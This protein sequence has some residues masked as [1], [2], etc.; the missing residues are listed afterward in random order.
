[1]AIQDLLTTV[2]WARDIFK[3]LINTWKTIAEGF[4]QWQMN[5]QAPQ[6][7]INVWW[8]NDNATFDQNSFSWQIQNIMKETWLNPNSTEMQDL[9]AFLSQSTS[10][11]I[12]WWLNVNRENLKQTTG[13]NTLAT[14]ESTLISDYLNSIKKMPW[15]ASIQKNYMDKV[16]NDDINYFIWQLSKNRDSVYEM[17]LSEA[18]KRWDIV[19][20]YEVMQNAKQVQSMYDTKINEAIEIKKQRVADAKDYAKLEYEDMMNRVKISQDMLDRARVMKQDALE[21][22]RNWT[23][24]YKWL[25]ELE[26]TEKKMNKDYKL[27]LKELQ[28]STWFQN[29]DLLLKL[30][31]YENKTWETLDPTQKKYYFDEAINAKSNILSAVVNWKENS[32]D[33]VNVLKQ[34]SKGLNNYEDLWWIV[35]V[36]DS[37]KTNELLWKQGWTVAWRTNNPWNIIWSWNLETAKW[38]WAIWVYKNYWNMKSNWQPWSYLVFKT[39]EEGANAM[40][41]LMLYWKSYRNKTVADR[42]VQWQWWSSSA[43]NILKQSNPGLLSKRNWFTSEDMAAITNAVWNS[44]GWKEWTLL[45]IW[46]NTNLT[47]QIRQRA[48]ELKA[49]WATWQQTNSLLKQEFKAQTQNIPEV[50]T[51]VYPDFKPSNWQL[52]NVVQKL[53]TW[54]YV[55]TKTYKD[56]QT[57]S[58]FNSTQLAKD[59]SSVNELNWLAWDA[60]YTKLADNII[61]NYWQQLSLWDLMNTIYQFSIPNDYYVNEFKKLWYDEKT[62]AQSVMDSLIDWSTDD[63]KTDLVK[64]LYNNVYQDPGFYKK[65]LFDK[66]GGSWTEWLPYRWQ[67]ESIYDLA[68]NE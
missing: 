4:Q 7:S 32:S 42:L 30:K 9:A 63:E 10:G 38:L 53:S 47:N 1:M 50:L 39:P 21:E 46:N 54:A 51:S 2:T 22:V 55:T 36:S 14:Q 61:S 60:L 29:A 35:A 13:Y 17:M 34:Q 64:Y 3:G 33:A 43:L 8:P 37:N 26:S 5:A 20:P 23:A 56:W 6:D 45:D 52:D 19:N 31:D 68:I 44:E 49:A 12:A 58:E 27:R 41:K 24:D 11:Q 67:A 48:N 18:K 66:Y 62:I 15:Y 28:L 16:N 40:A 59:L 25:A 57:S 65:Y